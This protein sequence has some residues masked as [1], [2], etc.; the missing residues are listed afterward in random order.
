MVQPSVGGKLDIHP[1]SRSCA[2]KHQGGQTGSTVEDYGERRETQGQQISV[3][4]N[5][6]GKTGK[7]VNDRL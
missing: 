1:T 6:T 5:V 7:F 2:V 3:G 4:V